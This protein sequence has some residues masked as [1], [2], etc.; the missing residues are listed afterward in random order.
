MIEQEQVAEIED[1]EIVVDASD[2]EQEETELEAV[3]SNEESEDNPD[4]ESDSEEATAEESASEDED[5]EIEVIEIEGEAPTPTED[6]EDTP[7]FR[8]MR[9]QLK[10]ALKENKKLKANAPVN[11]VTAELPILGKEPDI[12]D[13][14]ID[15]D[16]A[17]FKK[18]WTEWHNLGQRHK[19]VKADAKAETDKQTESWNNT[20]KDYDVKKSALKVKDFDDK[21]ELVKEKLSVQQQGIILHGASNPAKL[22]YALSQYPKLLDTLSKESDPT[23]FAFALGGLQGKLK[24][25]TR[26]AATKPERA[27]KG[28]SRIT[29][30]NTV[31]AGIEARAEKSNDRTEMAAYNRKQ[32]LKL[33]E[34]NKS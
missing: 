9:K 12:Y 23:K 21:E 13:D 18:R 33:A 10:D 29:S 24:T 27:I 4:S 34:Q 11:D 6:K 32:K 15:G 28:G 22:V 7:T 2:E 17:V 31:L 25:S 5:E 3:E 16:S 1:E 20:L 14:G 30:G 8:K 26:R 19:K